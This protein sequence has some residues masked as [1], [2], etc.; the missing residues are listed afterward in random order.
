MVRLDNSIFIRQVQLLLSILSSWRIKYRDEMMSV[1]NRGIFLNKTTAS[2]QNE[3]CSAGEFD[4]RASITHYRFIK[5]KMFAKFGNECILSS[6]CGLPH[7]IK[8]CTECI[9]A[10]VWFVWL[11]IEELIDLFNEITACQICIQVFPKL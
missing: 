10:N 4:L 5:L 6:E 2:R 1:G 11:I 7:P 8:T 9:R 3:L